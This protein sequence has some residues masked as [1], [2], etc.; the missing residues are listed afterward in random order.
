MSCL[1]Y[2]ISRSHSSHIFRGP[3]TII[4]ITII[5]CMSAAHT[6]T[7]NVEYWRWHAGL[8]RVQSKAELSLQLK[9]PLWSKAES[10][11]AGCLSPL[12]TLTPD[13]QDTRLQ[14]HHAFLDI[15]AY[16][17]THQVHSWR[18]KAG[19]PRDSRMQWRETEPGLKAPPRHILY[20]AIK[21][22]GY[23]QTVH[24]LEWPSVWWSAL[25]SRAFYCPGNGCLYIHSIYGQ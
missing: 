5:Y 4:T 9:S 24:P 18:R 23:G 8:N 7:T 13:S 15:N 19:W 12:L 11:W 25:V 3:I 1:K 20:E 14:L 22:K 2:K 10:L 21:R 6:H 17:P 16:I